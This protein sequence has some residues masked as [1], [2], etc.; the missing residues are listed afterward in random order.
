LELDMLKH[1]AILAV[2]L[3][4]TGCALVYPKATLPYR[5]CHTAKRDGWRALP[6]PPEQAAQLLAIAG[7][8]QASDNWALYW[9]DK[10]DG[11]ILLCQGDSAKRQYMAM[12]GCWDNTWKFIESDS[13]W[14]LAP[15]GARNSVC[16]TDLDSGAIDR[17]GREEK[18]KFPLALES[19]PRDETG[20]VF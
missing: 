3:L 20:A 13:G 11:N 4:A 16:L 17:R 5:A 6:K 8:P 18:V 7:N 1:I 19:P 10:P 12:M 14:Q 2:A 9:F 15:D